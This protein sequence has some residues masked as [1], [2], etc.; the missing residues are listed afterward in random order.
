MLSDKE[1]RS[2]IW[3]EYEEGEEEKEEAGESILDISHQ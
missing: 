1:I 3:I 2:L